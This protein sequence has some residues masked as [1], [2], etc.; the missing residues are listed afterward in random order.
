MD[1]KNFQRKQNYSKKKFFIDYK[2]NFQY[3]ISN[4]DYKH[5]LYPTN[6]LMVD[7]DAIKKA[8]ELENNINYSEDFDKSRFNFKNQKIVLKIKQIL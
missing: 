4:F 2:Y 6:V 8:S 7:H 5:N 3:Q 1:V